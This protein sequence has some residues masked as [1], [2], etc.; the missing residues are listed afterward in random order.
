MPK[1]LVYQIGSLGDTLVSIPAYR[2]IRRHFGTDA[3]IHVLHNAP[4]DVRAVPQ[5]VLA[6]S[7]LV[8]GSIGFTQKGG[9]SNWETLAKLWPRLVTRRFDAVVYVAPAERS[10]A[11]VRRDEIFFRLCG[12]RQM[13]G[14]HACNPDYF[15]A[16]DAAGRPKPMPQEAY[17]RLERLRRD[18]IETSEH[19]DLK[20]P[21][22]LPQASEVEAARTWLAENRRFPR[23][24]L[25]AIGPGANQPAKFWPLE[26]FEEIGHRL[27]EAGYEIVVIG[28]P[29][30]REAAGR[31]TAAWQDGL[32]TAGQ[33]SVTGTAALLRECVFLIGLDTG[34]THLAASVG[35]PV[36]A[37]YADRDPEGQW[38][39]LGEGHIVLSHAV[40]CAGCGLKA[41]PVPDHP[42]MTH[43]TVKSVWQAIERV[44]T[45][46]TAQA[47]L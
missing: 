22:V 38:T 42:C 37:L 40:P 3:Q 36:I 24:P 7:G 14:F 46:V 13:F 30:E 44:G 25:A 20:S 21:L 18:G 9:R 47:A 6:G 23:R 33:F 39:P 45:H 10:A 2:A 16:R 28:G 34:T 19:D 4:S 35:T 32:N 8:D 11:S 31:L 12:I 41:C 29:A 26:R 5:Q 1:V 17:L 43:I 27:R 15:Q